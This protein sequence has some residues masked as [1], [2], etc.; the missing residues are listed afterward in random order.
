M[1]SIRYGLRFVCSPG[2]H[3]QQRLVL[4]L[5]LYAYHQTPDSPIRD[6]FVTVCRY[7][8]LDQHLRD[9]SEND[10]DDDDEDES[11]ELQQVNDR[12]VKTIV[13]LMHSSPTQ[14]IVNNC[15]LRRPNE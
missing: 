13:Q 2:L 1:T 6:D 9:P 3:H 8:S 5:L 12:L 15:F 10:D 11:E 4:N 14:T 7:A